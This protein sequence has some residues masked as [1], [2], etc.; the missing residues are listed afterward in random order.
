MPYME[1]KTLDDI[2]RRLEVIAQTLEEQRIAHDQIIQ[3]VEVQRIT[4]E[5]YANGLEDG[6]AR[7]RI[8]L[9]ASTFILDE[10]ENI[11]AQAA[12]NI[13]ERRNGQ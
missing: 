3:T 7:A 4:L 10:P 5:A 13:A 9:V 2:E 6:G 11:V 12:Q 1:Q 8:T